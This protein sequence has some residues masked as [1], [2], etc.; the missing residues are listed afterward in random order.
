MR[1]ARIELTDASSVGAARRDAMRLAEDAGASRNKSSNVGICATELATNVVLHA[2]RGELL[3]FVSHRLEEVFAITDRVT[4]MREGRTVAKSLPTGSLSQAELIRLMVGQE[5]KP[6]S[7][8]EMKHSAIRASRPVVL[9]VTNLGSLPGV[10]DVSLKVHQGEI[11]G[12]GGLVGA[13]RCRHDIGNIRVSSSRCERG[14][15]YHAADVV[16]RFRR[17]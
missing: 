2:R 7:P 6:S 16:D 14:A 11:L 4:V 1:S 9:E 8:D 17:E 3:V 10:R 5:M 15:G 13:G 12:L